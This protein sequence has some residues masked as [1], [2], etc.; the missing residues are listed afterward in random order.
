M[1][2]LFP[3]VFFLPLFLLACCTTKNNKQ[4]VNTSKE[5]QPLTLGL[6]PSMD[7]L[8]FVIARQQGFYDSLGIEVNFIKYYSPIE[9]D[10]ALQSG[11]I[12]GAITDYSSAILLQVKGTRLGLVMQTDGYC[13]LIAGKESGIRKPEQLK[14]KNIAVS[15]N[16][17]I[18]YATDKMM[19]HTG[20]TS[21]QVNKPEIN[22]IPLRLAM[23]ENGQIDATFLPAP[24]TCMAMSNGGHLLGSTRQM[25]IA[26]TGTAFNEKALKE[27]AEEIKRLITGYNLGVEYLRKHPISKWSQLV[28]EDTG[29][30][31]TQVGSLMLPVY[32]LAVR[33]DSCD[34]A[35]AIHWLQKKRALP[36]G[37]SS[38]NLVDTAFAPKPLKPQ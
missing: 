5:L 33:P 2:K 6:M 14:E 22:N 8:P 34:I 12:D 16:T 25:K 19:E 27:K 23:L 36:E 31:E 9:R 38:K 18:E 30:S 4:E 32:H 24:Y 7:G 1:R 28:I 15:H 37:Y 21:N 11:S 20:I 29:L 35:N 13:Q 17:I 3:A 10:A 26:F